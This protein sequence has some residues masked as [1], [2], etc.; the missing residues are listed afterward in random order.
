MTAQVSPDF[1]LNEVRGFEAQH[2]L[3]SAL[4]RFQFI[5][6]GLDLPPFRVDSGEI[7]RAGLAWPGLAW[8]GLAWLQ[9]RGEQPIR[10]GFSLPSSIV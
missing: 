5:E 10:L 4:M 9:D 6:G 1:L 2:A 8:P 3:R 7:F